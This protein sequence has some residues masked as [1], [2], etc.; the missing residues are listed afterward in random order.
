MPDGESGADVYDRVTTFIGSLHRDFEK[1]IFPLAIAIVS[2]GLTIKAFLMRWF[3][4]SVEDFDLIKTPE[5]CSL[6]KMVI[7]HETH[8]YT[9]ITTLKRRTYPTEPKSN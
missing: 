1:E 3:K 5:N 9:L 7:N 2:H 4:W 8:K 6:I